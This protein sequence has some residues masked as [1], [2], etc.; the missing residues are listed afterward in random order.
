M[1][2]MKTISIKNILFASLLVFFCMQIAEECELAN[3][4]ISSR[5]PVSININIV[6]AKWDD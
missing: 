2:I 3:E 1:F 5:G 6:S 4:N